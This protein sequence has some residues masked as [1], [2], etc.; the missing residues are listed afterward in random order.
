MSLKFHIRILKFEDKTIDQSWGSREH[1]EPFWRL[2]INK[3]NG[4]SLGLADGSY[5]ITANRIHFVPAWVRF[6]C[7]NTRPLRHFYVHFEPVGIGSSVQREVFDRPFRA[8]EKTD[9]TLISRFPLKNFTPETP[10]DL[11]SLC[12]VK[13]IVYREFA[14]FLLRLPKDRSRRL[15][16]L[17]TGNQA[18]AEVLQYIERHLAEP[19]DNDRLADLACMSKS[20]FIRSFHKTLG[21]TPGDYV[22]ERR[23]AAAALTL[24]LSD[25]TIDQIA[26]QYGFANR[27]YFSRVFRKIMGIAPAT[28]RKTPGV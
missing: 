24:N 25:D 17:M 22:Q 10:T 11:T 6:R 20:H 28:Y 21:Q 9:Y 3:C 18:F 14:G 13:S 19:L 16:H 2:Y 5:P 27:F 4:A 15:E 8:E 23:V 26:E 7:Q 1:C 12:Y